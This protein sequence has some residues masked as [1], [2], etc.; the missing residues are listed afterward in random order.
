MAKNDP[1]TTDI[2]DQPPAPLPPLKSSNIP[3]VEKI[4]EAETGHDGG[5]NPVDDDFTDGI[6]E[7][8]GEKYALCIHEADIYGNTHTLKNSVHFWQGKEA[9]FN[10]NFKKA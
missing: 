7:M 10:T 4:E 9:D 2:V 1:K 8:N 6:F 5:V 3:Q